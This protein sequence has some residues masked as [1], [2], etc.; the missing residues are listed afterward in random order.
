M[1]FLNYLY[2]AVAVVLLFGAAI[3]VHE[4]G[5]YWV[6][7]RRGLKDGGL[8]HR[9]WAEDF[10]LD[11]DGIEYSVALDS[12]GRFRQA[13]ANGHFRGHRRRGRRVKNIPPA[14]P[15]SK[16]LVAVAGPFMNVVFAFVIAS[17]IYFVGLPVPINPSIIGYVDPGFARGETGHP[18]GDK[19]VAVDGKPV[20]SWEE[21][22]N[23]PSWP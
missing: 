21:V 1:V 2:I 15:F 3:F 19:I 9:L 23:S 14:P 13:A 20:K 8:L 7:R 4:F 22:I 6:A 5:H 17:I 12:G 16:I 10:W 11:S 18:G